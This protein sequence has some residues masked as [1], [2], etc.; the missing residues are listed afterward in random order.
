MLLN[1]LL[2][3]SHNFAHKLRV[4]YPSHVETYFNGNTQEAEEAVKSVAQKHSIPDSTARG[5]FRTSPKIFVPESQD[6][7]FSFR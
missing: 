5:L 4:W 6:C 2:K 3:L 1:P 7:N